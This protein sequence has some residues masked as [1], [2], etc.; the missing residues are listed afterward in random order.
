[1]TKE[2][3][4]WGIVQ[5]IMDNHGDEV[6]NISIHE[7]GDWID[8]YEEGLKIYCSE[9]FC[10]ELSREK[11]CEPE[12]VNET[13]VQDLQDDGFVYSFSEPW[14][15]FKESGIDKAIKIL[16]AYGVAELA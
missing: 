16:G 8:D 12:E 15:G 1:M 7:S 5:N 13:A 4:L 11:C 10:W 9:G 2:K 6:D 14:D 3:K